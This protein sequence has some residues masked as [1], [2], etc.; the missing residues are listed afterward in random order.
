MY[1]FVLH[2]CAIASSS[3]IQLDR[4]RWV[5]CQL[6]VLRRLNSVSAVRKA[7]RRLPETLDET[8]ERILTNIPKEGRILAQKTFRWLS[9]E[10]A[11]EYLDDLCAAVVLDDAQCTSSSDRQFFNARYLQ[12]I[13]SS[14]IRIYHDQDLDKSR[15]AFAHYTVKEFL[16][17]IRMEQGPAADYHLSQDSVQVFAAKTSVTYLMNLQHDSLYGPNEELFDLSQIERN[18]PFFDHATS[19]WGGYATAVDGDDDTVSE[20]VLELLDHSK[21]PFQEL[22]ALLSLREDLHD[23]PT[24]PFSDWIRTSTNQCA[25]QLVRILETKLFG[26][27]E[28]FLERQQDPS[29]LNTRLEKDPRASGLERYVYPS[30]VTPFEVAISRGFPDIDK[31]L[32]D[33]VAKATATNTMLLT[34]LSRHS[35]L[36]SFAGA[37]HVELLLA[38]EADPNPP[39]VRVTPLQMS[40]SRGLHETITRLVEAGAHVNGVG[41]G[42]GMEYDEFWVI[43][44]SDSPLR[45]VEERLNG[46]L[47]SREREE[48]VPIR[49]LLLEHGARSFTTRSSADDDYTFSKD[50]EEDSDGWSTAAECGV[51]P[52]E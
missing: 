7:L 32:L 2:S 17:S 50:L 27:A 41:E 12:R 25:I 45:M 36:S 3:L 40:I 29:I 24:F 4:F 11:I 28:M 14:L 38:A 46:M 48:Y 39:G 1:L 15:V 51:V 19:S 5:A 20:A 22:N 42:N 18:E 8:Y 23:C 34:A 31:W 44:G 9:A 47:N 49:D 16:F 35:L 30:I 6:D 21:F 43:D 10:P 37:K 33:G 13:C 52:L 26:V